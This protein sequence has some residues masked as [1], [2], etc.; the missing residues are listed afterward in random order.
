MLLEEER[1]AAQNGFGQCCAKLYQQAHAYSVL[2]FGSVCFQL[3]QS[4]EMVQ[5]NH[6]QAHTYQGQYLWCGPN[7]TL[8]CVN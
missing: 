5:K 2:M 4:Q 6:T 8:E 7:L 3:F 1:D